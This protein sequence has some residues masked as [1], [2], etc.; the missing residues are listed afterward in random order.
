MNVEF[1][2]NQDTRAMT[3][4]VL[5][6]VEKLMHGLR[7]DTSAIGAEHIE[8]YEAGFRACKKAFLEALADD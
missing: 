7:P 1:V 3:E 4:A 2:T 8:G 5:K 6:Q